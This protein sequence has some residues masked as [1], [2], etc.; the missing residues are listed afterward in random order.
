MRPGGIRREVDRGEEA[1][2]RH[3]VAWPRRDE[4][5]VIVVVLRTKSDAGVDRVGGRIGHVRGEKERALS[6]AQQFARQAPRSA[7]SHSR[8]SDAREACRPARC[9][10]FRAPR[11]LKPAK[12]TG[13]PLS[14]THISSR[15]MRFGSHIRTRSAASGMPT[16]VMNAICASMSHGTSASPATRAHPRRPGTSAT[17]VN[18]CWRRLHAQGV[19]APG[20]LAP[21]PRE[22]LRRSERAHDALQVRQVG[23]EIV[24][25]RGRRVRVARAED[26][27]PLVALHGDAE[28]TVVLARRE[29]DAARPRWAASALPHAPTR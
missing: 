11:P 14:Q 25:E 3:R 8:D 28:D 17:S 1:R 16:S 13:P 21:P 7:S 27:R 23:D 24:G 2:D 20:P 29:I 10:P 5:V 9:A 18:R 22:R 6:A 26:R 15:S 12:A 19:H 4:I